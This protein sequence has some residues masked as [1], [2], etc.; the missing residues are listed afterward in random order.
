MA[1]L[2][3]LT[4]KTPTPNPTPPPPNLATTPKA[5]PLSPPPSQ[6]DNQHTSPTQPQKPG[7]E[8][9]IQDIIAPPSIEVDFSHLKIGSTYFRTI[10]IA[11]YPRYVS[12]NWLSPLINFDH[13]IDV[14]MFIYPVEVK[15]TLEQL[16]RRI[17]EMEAEISADI[18]RGRIPQASTQ[19][20]LE[21]ANSLQEQLVK[22]I[23]RFF[24]F[25]LYI[26]ISADSKKE[27]DTVT[28]QVQSL[29]G[30]LII[31]SKIASYSQVE[32]FKSTLPYCKDKLLI[33]RNMDTTALST[34][35]PFTS[36]ELTDN[37]GVLFG[38][39][40]HNESLV[41]FDRFSMEN[42]NMLILATSG[43]G[44]SYAVKI[45]IMRSLMFG[46]HVIIIDPENEYE[47]LCKAVGGNYIA[48]NVSSNHKIN[49]FQ[50]ADPDNSSEDEMGYK[51]LY[52]N[53]LLKIM[54]G[55]MSADE[56][57]ILNQ[58]LV[59]AYQQK[60]ITQDPLTHT[61]EP[62][63]MEDLYKA[64]IGM[65][66]P[67]AISLSR[68]LE[69]YVKGALKGIFDQQS[70]VSIDSPITVFTLRELADEIRPIVMF[71]ILD[72]IWTQIRKELK[73]RLLVVDEAWYLMRH[74]D[75]AK[76]LQGL[77]K[78]A[79]KYYLGVSII[80]QN[81]DDFLG[82]PYGKAIVTNSA[83]QFLMK[84]SPA[85]IDE[86]AQVFYLSQGERSL[87]LSANVGEGLFF[88]GQNHIALRVVGSPDEHALA[89]SKPQDIL[90][91][92]QQAKKEQS[93]SSAL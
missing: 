66:E 42:A 47:M 19:A 8:V 58:A 34:T 11:G 53:S 51:Y 64:L 16:R 61:K 32:A 1:F 55:S 2:P 82:S 90:A 54:L 75:S 9:N 43:A 25:S 45:E 56:D 24:Q 79:R 14:S 86:V 69:K 41:I 36:S 31:V 74:E 91:R 68:R 37:K 21:D 60:G 48:F 5:S 71:M 39:N 28:S 22:G 29:L 85:A 73:R 23:E 26:T 18:E 78:R 65:E 93:L 3:F 30:S 27:L 80:S 49:P 81:A 59:L 33:T 35:F 13:S 57:A 50:L 83:I 7:G 12:A 67:E 52:L 17:A 62:P 72:Y 92:Q 15:G 38:I 20:Q 46:T 88:A 87:L 4:K 84:Q 10:F 76:V 6:P 89:T 63:R 77:V 44:K 40:E 70:N